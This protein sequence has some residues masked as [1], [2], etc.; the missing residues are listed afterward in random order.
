MYGQIE[1]FADHVSIILKKC[2]GDIKSRFLKGFL[3]GGKSDGPLIVGILFRW[4]FLTDVWMYSPTTNYDADLTCASGIN[5]CSL[6]KPRTQNRIFCF[7]LGE[8]FCFVLK[9]NLTYTVDTH[10]NCQIV[11]GHRFS[12]PVFSESISEIFWA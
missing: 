4:C 10:Q 1:G 9:R 11:K 7:S 12:K 3:K 2:L 5:D 8:C 6:Y